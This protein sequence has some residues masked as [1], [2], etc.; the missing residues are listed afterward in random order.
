MIIISIFSLVLNICLKFFTLCLYVSAISETPGWFYSTYDWTMGV[1]I[2]FAMFLPWSS[3]N[4]AGMI[5]TLI[6]DADMRIFTFRCLQQIYFSFS[7]GLVHC[8]ICFGDLLS[9][10]VCWIYNSK[11][12]SCPGVW[13]WEL[14]PYHKLPV[15]LYW[16]ND[17]IFF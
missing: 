17:A 11:N 10:S 1:C 4:N 14:S 6:A 7:S 13:W 3:I 15:F 5:K 8:N 12:R 16:C 2:L 9:K